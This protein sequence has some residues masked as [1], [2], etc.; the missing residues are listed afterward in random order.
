MNSAGRT[1]FKMEVC[2]DNP[3][4][5]LDLEGLF[6]NKTFHARELG[7][8]KPRTWPSCFIRPRSLQDKRTVNFVITK[9][10]GLSYQPSQ[11][12]HAQNPQIV[13]TLYQAYTTAERTVVG[14]KGGHVAKDVLK[15]QNIPYIAQN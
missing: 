6:I 12:K 4:L 9:I 1:F 2:Q 5:I 14:Y 8:L 13:S 11:T 3:C 10:H 7:Y 15:Q